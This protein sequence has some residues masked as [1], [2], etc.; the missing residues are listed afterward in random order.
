MQCA[1]PKTKKFAA[2]KLCPFW[3]RWFYTGVCVRELS[4]GVSVMR[5][6]LLTLASNAFQAFGTSVLFYG[7]VTEIL[8]HVTPTA[9]LLFSYSQC[10]FSHPSVLSSPSPHISRFKVSHRKTCR[11]YRNKCTFGTMIVP[12]MMKRPKSKRPKT[13]PGRARCDVPLLH[14]PTASA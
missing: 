3:A 9:L 2:K 1:S 5:Q 6:Q 14:G 4:Y 8:H 11:Q 10:A 7:Y 12:G 13:F